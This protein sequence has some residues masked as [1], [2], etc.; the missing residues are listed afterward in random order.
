M[1]RLRIIELKRIII[2]KI[3]YFQVG[4]EHTCASVTPDALTLKVLF[5]LEFSDLYN[6]ISCHLI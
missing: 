3:S 2:E 1:K 5:K 4:I 6:S